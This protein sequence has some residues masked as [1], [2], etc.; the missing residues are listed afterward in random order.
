MKYMLHVIL[1]MSLCFPL[2][3]SFTPSP[4]C[5]SLF[6][7]PQST[8]S[9]ILSTPY[10]VIVQGW[11]TF[12]E[13]CS[14]KSSSHLL[15]G[16]RCFTCCDLRA[17]NMMWVSRVSRLFRMLSLLQSNMPK[18]TSCNQEQS[19]TRRSRVTGSVRVTGTQW[20]LHRKR[21]P[22]EVPDLLYVSG[23]YGLLSGSQEE[24]TFPQQR[25]EHTEGDG[26]RCR[27]QVPFSIIQG[28]TRA[29]LSAGML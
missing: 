15:N 3:S 28:V 13:L 10:Y 2:F 7:L 8:N 26:F 21:Q 16:W 9:A 23:G 25:L 17:G 22:S 19:S 29:A 12:T 4:G 11:N 1:L 18:F 5:P 14:V 24:Q 6:F 27:E 20:G